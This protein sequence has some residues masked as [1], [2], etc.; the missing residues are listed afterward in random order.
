MREADGVLAVMRGS[1]AKTVAWG[2]RS[3]NPPQ[4]GQGPER[5]KLW[6]SM[7]LGFRPEPPAIRGPDFVFEGPT[8]AHLKGTHFALVAFSGQLVSEK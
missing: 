4:A 8:Q 3:H 1:S 5:G 6:V 7:G 2:S